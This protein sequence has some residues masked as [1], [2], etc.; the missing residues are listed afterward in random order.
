MGKTYVAGAFLRS[1]A[2]KEVAAG[3][4][5]LVI[6]VSKTAELA[7]DQ[8]YPVGAKVECT[9]F[10]LS[11]TKKLVSEIDSNS[12]A[13]I[14]I[15]RTSLRQLFHF[16]KEDKIAPKMPALIQELSIDTVL[17]AG[18][19]VHGCCVSSEYTGATGRVPMF[20]GAKFCNIDQENRTV[21]NNFIHEELVHTG[22][23]HQDPVSATRD[24]PADALCSAS[25]LGRV[26]WREP[27]QREKIEAVQEVPALVK[28]FIQYHMHK[29]GCTPSL[30]EFMLAPTDIPDELAKLRSQF[31]MSDDL[32]CHACVAGM[33]HSMGE[34]F[35]LARLSR[36]QGMD[37][38]K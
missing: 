29:D 16:Q 37:K 11:K 28:L 38:S 26:R 35:P 20:I 9:P 5:V 18:D 6:Y 15:T 1:S 32:S 23:D 8:A 19:E 17:L 12:M 33:N 14:S 3:K 10:Q 30:S 24:K 4:R 2:E 31:R 22:C 13:C 34:G 27:T 25:P 36:T 21:R 7:K